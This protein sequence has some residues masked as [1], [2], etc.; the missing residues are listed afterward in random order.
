[1]I[2]NIIYVILSYILVVVVLFLY[3]FME[4]SP[5]Q[6]IAYD[7]FKSGK[8]M[9]LTGPGGT[10]KSAFIR[11]I[12]QE[13][14]MRGQH[15][16]VC[17]MTGCA[18]VML[19]CKASTIH[20]WGGIGICN[21]TIDKIVDKVNR[22]YIA[23]PAWKNVQVLVVDEVS[24]MSQKVFEVLDTIGKK[25]RKNKKPFGGI[26]L[27]FT[28]DFYQLPPVF[29]SGKLTEKELTE[30]EKMESRFCF[31]SPRWLETFPWENHVSL[32]KIFR[33]TDVIYQKI[34]NQLRKGEL[35]KSSY[36]ILLKHIGKEI[37]EINGVK[38]KPTQLF[39]TRNQAKMVNFIEMSNLD[40]EEKEYN[41]KRR[42]N[43]EMKP[44][45]KIKQMGFTQE[46]MDRELAYLEGNLMCDAVLTLKV[47]AQ[48]MCVVNIRITNGDMIC[49][50]SQGIVTAFE[51]G[52]GL[53]VVRFYRGGIEMTMEPN[54]W[55]SNNIPG[56]G[57]SQVPLIQAWALTIHKSQGATLDM[58][59][60]DAGSGIFEC[61]QTYVALSRV[62]SLDGLYLSAFDPK[63]VRIN[64]A[65]SEFYAQMFIEESKR[66]Q[67]KPVTDVVTNADANADANANANAD[68]TK[69]AIPIAE[70]VET[71]LISTTKKDD[72]NDNCQ[73]EDN[74]PVA[75]AYAV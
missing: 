19:D 54:V 45:E 18:A 21:G 11:H 10:G 22:N 2:W 55:P 13:M 66:E 48:V 71:K 64:S 62:K 36:N 31:Q 29:K 39:P 9:F 6:K 27:L 63:R 38:F 53:P 67:K 34:L 75:V 58:A 30:D 1:M 4:F 65:V 50:G 26:Q 25:I 60:I 7:L 70:V 16:A 74:L 33:Q 47:G 51:P 43:L 73:V 12:Q 68:D 37:P 20:S 40:G 61:G 24:M 44:E 35:K 52:T 32:A 46:Q 5:E 49:N 69:K 8:N 56:I 57:V 3:R 72:N 41:I 17:A 15:I 28:G 59:E 23:K 14:L 42:Y